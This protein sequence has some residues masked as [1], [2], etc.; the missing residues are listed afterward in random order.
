MEKI[1][2]KAARVNAGFTLETAAEALQTYPQV[3][4]RWETGESEPRVSSFAAACKL[5][6]RTMD[7]VLVPEKSP[8]R[9]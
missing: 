3:I 5:Y 9:G 8:L 2:L 6:G 7:S 4:S 1:T